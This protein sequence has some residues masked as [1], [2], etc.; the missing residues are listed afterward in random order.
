MAALDMSPERIERIRQRSAV[1][2]ER[3]RIEVMPNHRR[4]CEEKE[5]QHPNRVR[6]DDE[7]SRAIESNPLTAELRRLQ[8]VCPHDFTEFQED[9]TWPVPARTKRCLICRSN[10]TVFGQLTTAREVK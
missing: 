6:F 9:K 8:R 7:I 3:I 5:K 1:L 10:E 4:R 2:I